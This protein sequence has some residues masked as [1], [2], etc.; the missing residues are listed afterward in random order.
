MSKITCK[1]LFVDAKGKILGERI[2][3][4]INGYFAGRA[5]KTTLDTDKAL[6]VA[7]SVGTH[8]GKNPTATVLGS[9]GR[10]LAE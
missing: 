2:E 6:N 3:Y 1:E 10:F 7:R 9:M 5:G 4:W 8:C